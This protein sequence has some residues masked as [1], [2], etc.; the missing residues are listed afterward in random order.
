MARLSIPSPGLRPRLTRETAFS[1]GQTPGI[2]IVMAQITEVKIASQAGLGG[3]ATV[4]SARPARVGAKIKLFFKSAVFW[5]YARGG[6][7]Y[8]IIVLVILAFIFLTPRSWFHD[9]PTLQLSD[10]RHLQGV[11]EIRSAKGWRSYQ[12]DARLVDSLHAQSP[13]QAVRQ[14]LEQHLKGTPEIESVQPIR[15][16]NQVIL[17]YTVVVAQ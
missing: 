10:V 16:K 17:G 7:Q 12:I 15:D 13:E 14:I 8:D 2:L 3:P 9:R 6:W 5:S 4:T 1:P 11:I